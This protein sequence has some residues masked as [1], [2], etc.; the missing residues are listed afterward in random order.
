MTPQILFLHKEPDPMNAATRYWFSVDGVHHALVESPCGLS[1]IDQDGYP[2]PESHARL[3]A[4]LSNRLTD[5]I[6]YA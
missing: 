2:L 1:L 5:D 3:L 6:R 4:A